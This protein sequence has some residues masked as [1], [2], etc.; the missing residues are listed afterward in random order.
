MRDHG[1]RALALGEWGEGRE[2]K[3]DLPAIPQPHRYVGLFVFDFGEWTSVGYTAEEIV[4]LL[5][6]AEHTGGQ[7]Y[8]IHRVDDAGCIELAGVGSM[9]LRGENLLLFASY[10][11]EPAE[12][13]FARLRVLAG[14]HPPPCALRIELVDLPGHSP[15]HAVALLFSRHVM[16]QVSDWLTTIGFQGG[17]VVSGGGDAVDSYREAATDPIATLHLHA[18][19]TL[20]SRSAAEVLRTVRNPLQR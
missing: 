18:Q 20:T 16:G 5:E 11:C 12:R 7:A 14:D 10:A 3:M 13:D 6:S 4:V 19:A 1:F 15:P 9:E 17:E 2:R 8:R